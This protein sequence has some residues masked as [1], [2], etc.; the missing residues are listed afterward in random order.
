MWSSLLVVVE[1]RVAGRMAG[2]A[3]AG[4]PLISCGK[5]FARRSGVANCNSPVF[6]SKRTG[7]ALGCGGDEPASSPR[8]QLG[9]QV[10]LGLIMSDRGR[11][12]RVAPN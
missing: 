12:L 3:M 10:N 8:V 5:G 9:M 7:G 6:V 4:T 11:P 2:Q 1:R